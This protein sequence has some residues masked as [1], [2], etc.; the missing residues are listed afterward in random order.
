MSNIEYLAETI[1]SYDDSGSDID[2]VV[3]FAA[4]GGRIPPH[5]LESEQSVLGAVLIDNDAAPVIAFYS[6]ANTCTIE[7]IMKALNNPVVYGRIEG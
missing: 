1:D 7:E 6:E 4:G 3:G 5:S 2:P